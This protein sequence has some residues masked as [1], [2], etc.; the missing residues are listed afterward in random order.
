MDDNT[1]DA[2]LS[3]YKSK[4]NK[5]SLMEVEEMFKNVTTQLDIYKLADDLKKNGFTSQELGKYMLEAR[6]RIQKQAVKVQGLTP[7]VPRT[8]SIPEYATTSLNIRY[9]NINSNNIK[10]IE[11]NGAVVIVI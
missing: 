8:M 4:R 3:E 1:L 5:P 7:I 11:E 10:L 9:E 2:M 6:I